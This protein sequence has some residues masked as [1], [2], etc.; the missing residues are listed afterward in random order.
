MHC[1]KQGT[2][3]LVVKEEMSGCNAENKGHLFWWLKKRCLGA[4]QNDGQ[5]RERLGKSVRWACSQ[6]WRMGKCVGV[7]WR[8]SMSIDA[9]V[10]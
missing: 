2:P 1:R 8:G 3:P 7:N 9:C 10:L 6:S 4:L 5:K